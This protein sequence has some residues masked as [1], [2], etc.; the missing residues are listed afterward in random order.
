M[1]LDPLRVALA[2]KSGLS[3]VCATC[4]KYWEGRDRGLPDPQCT[5][6]TNCGS[7]LAG[8]DFHDYTGPMGGNL[9]DWCFVCGSLSTHGVRIRKKVR[10]R[11][12]GVCDEHLPYLVQLE[13]V[14]V[15]PAVLQGREISGP[16]GLLSPESLIKPRYKQSLGEAMYEVESYYAKREGRELDL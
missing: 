7:P 15:S 11:T 13:P 6:I 1:A 4:T 12:V 14:G 10:S 16:S 2:V 8:D 5:S 3:V 9:S